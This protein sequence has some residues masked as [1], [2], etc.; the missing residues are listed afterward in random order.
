MFAAIL[1][2]ATTEKRCRLT[3]KADGIHTTPFN[4]KTPLRKQL[5]LFGSTCAVKRARPLALGVDSEQFCDLLVL[6]GNP[7]QRTDASSIEA[8]RTLQGR[9]GVQQEWCECRLPFVLV[10]GICCFGDI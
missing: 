7:R 5:N 4:T 9:L 10:Y 8:R 6:C 1:Y 3:Q 2:I